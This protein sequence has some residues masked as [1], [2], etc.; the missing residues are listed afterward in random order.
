ML[1]AALL[2]VGTCNLFIAPIISH[3]FKLFMNLRNLIIRNCIRAR[4]NEVF[5]SEGLLDK[6]FIVT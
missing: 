4:I 2:A 1:L 5:D 6:V 3:I